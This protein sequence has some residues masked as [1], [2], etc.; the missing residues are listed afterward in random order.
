MKTTNKPFP[1]PVNRTFR[2]QPDRRLLWDDIKRNGIRFLAL[3]LSCFPAVSC[4]HTL[5]PRAD[6]KAGA[7]ARVKDYVD[8]CQASQ[9]VLS[10]EGEFITVFNEQVVDWVKQELNAPLL[11]EIR[12]ALAPYLRIDLNERGFA[13]AAT[14]A[15]EGKKDDTNYNAIW[16]RD[17][18]WVY[19]SFLKQPERAGDALRLLLALWDYYA[20]D[21]QIKRFSNVIADPALSLN[22]M[23]MPHIRFDGSSPDLGDVM[24]N[25][26]PQIWNHRQIDA[27]GLFFAALGETISEGRV[28]LDD[29]TAERFKVLSLYPLF[30]KRIDFSNYE[31]AGAWE[32]IPRKNTSSIGLATRSLQIWRDLI[33][34]DRSPALGPFRDKFQAQMQSSDAQVAEQWTRSSLGQLINSGL[35]TVRHQLALGGESPDYNPEDVH[36]RLADIALSF[37]IQP[38]PLHGLS[39]AERRK[40]LLIVETLRR[41][42]GVLRYRHDSYQSGNYWIMAPPKKDKHV[43][44]LTGDTSSKAAFAERL[45]RL[46]PDSEAQWFFDSILA[47]D[48]LHLA[49]ITD[50]PELRRQDI[51]FATVHLKRA[52]GQITGNDVT[53]DGTPVKACQTP[54]SINTLIIDGRKYHLPSPIVPLNWAK[55]GLS[56]ALIEYQ[57]ITSWQ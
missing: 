10:P 6:A 52:L 13:P 4:K 31:D 40:I 35:K 46:I 32:E 23:A 16:V 47:L 2:R 22:D 36:F 14:R 12:T 42:C 21:A 33:H 11:K 30:L 18:V 50:D 41:P 55:A 24:V 37:I 8:S 29:L 28:T 39:E 5:G 25:G 49:K 15:N 1:F 56:M 44:A 53:A 54:E 43:A 48:R 20:T 7:Y 27:H 17:N 26:K 38:T 51:Y 57:R 45:S 3:V 9:I 19:Y 34:I